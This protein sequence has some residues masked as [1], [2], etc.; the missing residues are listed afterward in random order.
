MPELYIGN[1]SKQVHQFAYRMSERPGVIT[2]VVPI[3][4]QIRVSPN[5]QRTDLSMQEIDY[6][7]SQHLQ[8]GLTSVDN[9][10]SIGP[11]DGLCYSIGRSFTADKLHEGMLYKEQALGK[12]GKQIRTE[13]ALAV[14]QQIEQTTGSPLREL[15]MSFAE[16]EPRGGYQ[17]NDNSDHLAEGVRVTRNGTDPG[18]RRWQ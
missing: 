1:V 9:L 15:E 14:N 7:L 12:F 10:E 18:T 6:I 5:G 2:Q 17:H 13:A 3:G 16:Q 8:Y 4:G 11:H